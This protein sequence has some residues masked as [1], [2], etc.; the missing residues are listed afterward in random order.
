MGGWGGHEGQRLKDQATRRE[1]QG[2]DK[3]S[4]VESACC[5]YR[6]PGS[7]S[8]NPHSGSQP[9]ITS[10]P[11][12]LTPLLTSKGTRDTHIVQTYMQAKHIK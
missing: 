11:G 5:S 6:R 12:D 7:N 4:R 2:L 8:Q 9:S 3:W 10:V 1:S